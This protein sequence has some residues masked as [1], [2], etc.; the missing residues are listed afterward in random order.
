MSDQA[1]KVLQNKEVY[2]FLEGSGK[3][4]L[5]EYQGFSYG[6]PYLTAGDLHSYC[7]HFGVSAPGG[8]RWTYVEVLLQYA[9]ENSCC[10]ELLNYFFDLSH[11]KNLQGNKALSIPPVRDEDFERVHRQI[12]AAALDHINYLIRLKRKA[13]TL[14]DGHFYVMARD[15]SPVIQ[16]TNLDHFSSE[17]VADLLER[18]R[19]DFESGHYDSIIT[20]SRT[21]VEETLIHIVEDQKDKGFTTEEPNRSGDLVKLYN[22]VKTIKHMQQSSEYDKRVNEL[23]DGLEKIVNSIANL[24]NN[25]SDAHG[26]GAKRYNLHAREARLVMNAA[27]TFCE[28]LVSGKE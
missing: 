15:T 17:Y 24:R 11:F 16:T 25:V 27:M 19:E 13:L 8:S 3:N 2:E 21:L 5:I 18:C 14:T 7:Q 9:I 23:L 6:L 20:K 1:F 22:Q 26:M 12:V 4:D 28:Y 10:N